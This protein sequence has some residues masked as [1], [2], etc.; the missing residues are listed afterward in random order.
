MDT[1]Q[2]VVMETDLSLVAATQRYQQAEPWE[3][4][5]MRPSLD[6]ARAK[7]AAARYRLLFPDSVAVEQDIADAKELHRRIDAAAD[8]QQMIQ[9]LVDLAGLLVKFAH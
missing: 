9:A 2:Q 6:D 5:Q 3:K 8:T 7:W 4:A 1:D